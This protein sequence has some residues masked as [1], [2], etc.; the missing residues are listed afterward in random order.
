MRTAAAAHGAPLS[1]FQSGTPR[2]VSPT[3]PAPASSASLATSPQGGLG[4]GGTPNGSGDK[5]R[6]GPPPEPKPKLSRAERRELQEAQRAAKAERQVGGTSGGGAGSGSGASAGGASGGGAAPSGGV[7]TPAKA[8]SAGAGDKAAAST[9]GA[10]GAAQQQQRKPAVSEAVQFD[11]KRV[12][13]RL[14]KKSLVPRKE[15]DKAVELFAHLP[16][17]DTK[18]LQD[19]LSASS[20]A[21]VAGASSL[22]PCV[23][24]L[25]CAYADGVVTG[26]RARCLALLRAMRRL[27]AEYTTPPEKALARDLTSRVNVAVQFLIDC[28]PLG[29]AMGNAVKSLKQAIAAVGAAPPPGLSEADA[30]AALL[31]HIDRYITERI[32][33]ADKVI[34][35]YALSKIADGDVILTH[36]ASATV[37]SAL[38]AAH[39]AGRRFRVVIVDSRPRLEGRATLAALL[40]AGISCTYVHAHAVSYVM[41]DVTKVFLGAAAVLGNGAV[42]SRVGTAAV[43]MVA[44][45]K[46]APVL[47]LAH[48][49]KLHERTQLDSITN[50]E[51]G[52]PTALACVYGRPDITFLSHWEEA[53]RLRLL[54]L[55]YDVTPPEYVTM[56]VTEVGLLP[57]TS[58]PV[59]LREYRKESFL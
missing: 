19:A 29:V 25:G 52:D 4:D 34:E 33:L 14:Q 10:A 21:L 54:N 49:C 6:K 36:A 55:V 13:A 42:L 59:V 37:T 12:V 48:T 1:T 11:D 30:K 27:V 58:V 24:Q 50:N 31:E 39:T 40:R 57:P 47:V 38:V 43:A 15:S 3:S 5:P 45:A 32:L 35:Q 18:S 56:I 8:A 53:P 51:L 44:H 17:F 28:R 16:Q 41:K 7:T 2:P 22:H 46:G 26:G 23:M 20:P 9:A